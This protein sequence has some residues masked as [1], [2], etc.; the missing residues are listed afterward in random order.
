MG[1]EFNVT[2]WA[3]LI[4]AFAASYLIF[5]KADKEKGALKAVGYAIGSVAIIASLVVA[6]YAMHRQSSYARPFPG[7]PIMQG[8]PS[9][10]NI[11]QMLQRPDASRQPV[12]Q[13]PKQPAQP[14][15]AP[16][17]PPIGQ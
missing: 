12:G 5:I 16:K 10:P 1:F 6:G 11:Q 9:M 7:G 14:S 4:I 15:T 2:G 13:A 17:T 8:V 3:L